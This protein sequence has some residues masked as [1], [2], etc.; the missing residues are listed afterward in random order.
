MMRIYFQLYIYLIILKEFFK[1]SISIACIDSNS[2]T[3][4]I[5]EIFTLLN[6]VCNICI[7]RKNA[8]INCIKYYDCNNLKCTWQ[9]NAYTK[10]CTKYNCSGILNF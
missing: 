6:D 8:E 4:N 5:D 2:N 1:F 10:C 7:C 9:T 3:R